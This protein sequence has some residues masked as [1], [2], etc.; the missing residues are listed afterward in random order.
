[1]TYDQSDDPNHSSFWERFKQYEASETKR[2]VDARTPVFA[3]IDGRNFKRFTKGLNKPFD[4]RFTHAMIETAKYLVVQTGARVAYTQSDEI[5]LLWLADNDKQQMLYGGKVH[6]LTSVLASMATAAFMRAVLMSDDEFSAFARR[7]P[8]F[9]VRV[10]Q[11]P[12]K[13]EAANAILC[14][15]VDAQRHAVRTV[16]DFHEIGEVVEG[17]PMPAVVDR[18]REHGVDFNSYSVPFRRGMFIRRTMVEHLLEPEELERVPEHRRTANGGIMRRDAELLFLPRFTRVQNRVEVLFDGADPIVSE[19]VQ[20]E[21]MTVEEMLV[22]H[23]VEK[24]LNLVQAA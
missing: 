19:R 14:R 15:T 10:V 23:N 13:E 6:K 8:Q 18:F 4:G 17:L 24:P 1:M 2:F 3:R 12:S 22:Q 20:E 21:D 16:A 5:C 11:L 9:I 7:L